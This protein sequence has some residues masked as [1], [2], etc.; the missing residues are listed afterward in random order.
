MHT[1][2]STQRCTQASPPSRGPRACPRCR[3]SRPSGVRFGSHRLRV[4][5]ATAVAAV[6]TVGA[7]TGFSSAG[8]S[9]RLPRARRSAPSPS[10]PA[11]SQVQ[12]SPGRVS[13]VRASAT[14]S[15]CVL[16]SSLSRE[17]AARLES[18]VAEGHLL[19]AASLPSRRAPPASP[20]SPRRPHGPA[21]AGAGT[22]SWLLLLD[23][24]GRLTV[25]RPFH[26]LEPLWR[27]SSRRESGLDGCVKDSLSL[28]VVWENPWRLHM[29]SC[30]CPPPP[31]SPAPSSAQTSPPLAPSP[32]PHR[33]LGPA[34]PSRM[35]QTLPT[36]PS[37]PPA[38]TPCRLGLGTAGLP[39]PASPAM[40]PP[41]CVLACSGHFVLLLSLIKP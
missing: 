15:C 32:V 33:V 4:C 29:L 30:R 8:S 11:F 36:G 16:R 26:L 1:H 10:S 31:R 6:L 22:A 14:R 12:V 18:G 7:R 23:P 40:C 13:R 3:A 5:P 28:S 9:C 37:P 20:P 39:G 38:G 19:P 2:R 17:G 25:S 24:E 41:S 34:L 27:L 35:E 21:G